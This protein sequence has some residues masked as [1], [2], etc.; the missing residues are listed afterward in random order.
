MVVVVPRTKEGILRMYDVKVEILKESEGY[1]VI[2]KP[3]KD[4]IW[5]IMTLP[6]PKTPEE[7]K[8]DTGIELTKEYFGDRYYST[9]TYKFR[10][11]AEEMAKKLKK[12]FEREKEKA[13][14]ELENY[15][16]D[17]TDG[18]PLI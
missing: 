9:I 16:P 4:P 1:R 17:T 7:I 3:A 12:Y 11:E 14:K 2:L 18:I 13:M 10:E 15:T 5:G 6:L 8:R